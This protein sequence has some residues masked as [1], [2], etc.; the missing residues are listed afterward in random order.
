MPLCVVKELV[1]RLLFR[2]FYWPWRKLWLF[3][4]FH[5]YYFYPP[6]F[7]STVFQSY[8]CHLAYPLYLCFFHDGAIINMMLGTHLPLSEGTT[9]AITLYRLD[10]YLMINIM[11][12]M[13]INILILV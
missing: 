13:I 3:S 4:V 10:D 5:C 11:M 12:M 8:Q 9:F 7:R 6:P 1:F 2:W